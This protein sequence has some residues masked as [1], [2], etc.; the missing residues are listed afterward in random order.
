MTEYKSVTPEFKAVVHELVAQGKYSR[1]QYFSDINE[2][3]TTRAK[4]KNLQTEQGGEFLQLVTGESIRL[5]Q[6]Y[7]LDDHVNPGY[8]DYF[9]AS[10]DI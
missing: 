9:N 6:I 1:V 4:L 10:C 2:F 8:Q 5:D 3:L 7:R